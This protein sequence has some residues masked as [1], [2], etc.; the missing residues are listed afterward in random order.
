MNERD[1]WGIIESNLPKMVEKM[2][3]LQPNESV[4]VYCDPQG[5]NLSFGRPLDQINLKLCRITPPDLEGSYAVHRK[6]NG[7]VNDDGEEIA[8]EDL[9]AYLI[10]SIQG[11]KDGGAE[12]GWEFKLS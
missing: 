6:G 10:Q 5:R 11:M 7:Y 12:W 1:A 9:A 2:L 8:R 3:T 4:E